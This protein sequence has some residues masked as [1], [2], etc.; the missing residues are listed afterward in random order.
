MSMMHHRYVGLDVHRAT[1]SVAIADPDQPPVSYGKIPN[2]PTA[3]HKL[4]HR[5]GGPETIL[6]VAYEAGPTGYVVQRQLTAL[7]IACLVVAPSLIPVR[8]GDRVKTDRRDAL[9]LARLLRSGDL[10]PVWVPDQAHE[11]LRNLVR[12]RAAAKA[13][14]VRAKH[15][16]S[17]FLL[18]Q[19]ARP[20]IGVR[21]WCKRY[22]QWLRQLEF[23]EL[24]DRLVF[25]DYLA[26]VV[27]AGERVKRL[28]AGLRECART[29]PQATLI[30]ALQAF[31]GIGLL[32]A[33][34]IVA[35]AGEL[36][37]FATAPQFMAYTGAVPSEVSSGNKQSRGRITR[38]GNRALRHILGEAAQ[39]ARHAPWLSDE[40]KRRQKHAPQAVVE[41][42]WR[43]QVRLHARYRHLSGRLGPHKAIMAV[44]RELA[45]FVWAA[46]ALLAEGTP[47]A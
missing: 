45:G 9:K 19:G 2:E 44:A 38:A 18:C 13:D 24:A 34:T 41:L 14:E 27:D 42:A 30:Q 12:A 26:E 20:P 36:R 21:N 33:V 1:I 4:M 11:A 15:R 32:S 43:A 5:L 3:I 23:E 35:E 40:L 16:L 22:F 17:K 37:R 39:H 46:G 25:A 7:G 10:T 8:A 28:D 29:T 47:A 31:R 6:Q